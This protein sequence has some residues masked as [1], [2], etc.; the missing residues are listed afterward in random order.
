MLSGEG[1]T[2]AGESWESCV[3]SPG[4]AT[5]SVI[6]APARAGGRP[7]HR[8]SI[9]DGTVPVAMTGPGRPGV[10]LSPL[11]SSTSSGFDGRPGWEDLR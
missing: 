7:S 3:N 2:T 4:S 10:A 11:A 9:V 8:C 6:D 5:G 1:Q